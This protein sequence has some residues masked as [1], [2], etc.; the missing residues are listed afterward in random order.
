MRYPFKPLFF[1]TLGLLGFLELGLIQAGCA[2]PVFIE[3]SVVVHSR[4]GHFP[5]QAQIGVPGPVIYA[6]PPRLIYV[7][8][9][10]PRIV[11]APTVYRA[12]SGWHGHDRRWG[13][14]DEHRDGDRSERWDERRD[15]HHG[16]R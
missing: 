1:R 15:D 2:H 16:H 7:P 9:P 5:V 3:P 4:V 11:Y 6:P 14:R 8:P 12:P 13:R 10:P